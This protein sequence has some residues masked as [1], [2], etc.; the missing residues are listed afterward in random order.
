MKI[1]K[2]GT[3]KQINK[4]KRFDCHNCGCIFEADYTEYQPDS[5]GDTAFY[6]CKCPFCGSPTTV[7]ET[8]E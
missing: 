8:D 2:P 6:W 4:V 7:N 5:C 3:F 1:L